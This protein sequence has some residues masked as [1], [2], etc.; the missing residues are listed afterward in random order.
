MRDLAKLGAEEARG[1]SGIVFDLDDTL[2]DHGALEEAA[3]GALFRLRES[4][5]RLVACT[6]RP[7][8]WGEIAARMW[9][10]DVAVVE[11]GA[12]AWVR[13][14]VAAGAGR[15]RV[16][17]ET[18]LASHRA[19]RAD[20]LA[21]ADELV[22][23]FPDAALA[24]DNDA[25]V[26]DVT[27]DVGEHRR[28]SADDVATMRAVARDRGL[29]TFASSVHVHL[30]RDGNDKASGTIAALVSRF[31]D[32]ATAARS[33]YAFIGDSGN[34]AAAFAAFE[35]TFGVANV[36]RYVGAMSVP[37]KYVATAKMGLGFASI[38]ARI[39]LL[40]SGS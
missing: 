25:R 14:D 28:V 24:D 6:G 22:A 38:A 31:S 21:L 9:P 17:G 4:G 10:I 11:N 20:L 30:T 19:R 27:I 8:G 35:T 15:V 34:D 33:R 12:L 3:Y 39:A 29:F 5:L 16:L 23:R 32:D 36:R 37:P 18:S 26:T 7:S 40:R 2:L 1:L 13:D